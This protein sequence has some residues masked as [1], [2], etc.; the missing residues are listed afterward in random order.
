MTKAILT[1]TKIIVA[2]IAS[3]LMMSCQIEQGSANLTTQTRAIAE[4][5][6]KIAASDGIDVI[7]TQSAISSIHVEADDNLI[8]HI[9]T[10]IKGGT[11]H[12]EIKKRGLLDFTEKNVRVSMPQLTK[13][14]A[15]SGAEVKSTNEFRTEL[16]DVSASSGSEITLTV[17][18]DRVSA[19]SSSGSEIELSGMALVFEAAASS[20]SEIKAAR[21]LSNDVSVSA[22][23]GS[24]V[25][26]HPIRE[27]RATASSGASVDY[28]KSP[29][30]ISQNSTSGGSIRQ[31]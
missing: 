13:I 6:D 4:P 9:R 15:S 10:H 11:L 2:A 29:D 21:L 5:F 25:D 1:L 18:A 14:T 12:I 20:G 31:K 3:L 23:S 28:Y 24:G 27:L 30:K 26:V 16:L 19:A 7:L 22:S 8:D 17:S